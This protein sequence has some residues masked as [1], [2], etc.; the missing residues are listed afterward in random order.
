MKNIRKIYSNLAV[1]FI[2][3][4]I[5]YFL[6]FFPKPQP[7][8]EEKT[9]VYSSDDCK[10]VDFDVMNV[11]CDKGI[12]KIFIANKGG[13]ELNGTFLA[14][15]DTP[16]LQAFIGGSGERTLDVNKTQPVYFDFGK[17]DV[18]TRIEIIFQPCPFSTKII[19]NPNI[20]C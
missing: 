6:F 15:I 18:I 3:S 4:L 1:I 11:S 20:R 14:I 9:V 17:S 8:N 16:N 13:I 7:E 12:I 10:K 2:C 19:E 5:I